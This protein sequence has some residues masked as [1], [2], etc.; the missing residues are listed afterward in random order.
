MASPAPV[1]SARSPLWTPPFLAMGLV[2]LGFFSAFHVLTPTFPLY[3]QARHCSGLAMGVMVSA[4]M[5]ASLLARPLMGRWADRTAKKPLL[6]L[7]AGVFALCSPL[8]LLPLNDMA[9]LG[10]RLAQGVAFSLF[11]AAYYGYLLPVLPQARRAEALS[12]HSNLVMIALALGP[13]AGLWV[14]R[15]V[16]L[17]TVF[18]VSLA[19]GLL[20]LLLCLAL[21]AEAAQQ[22][23]A[24]AESTS[25]GVSG[26]WI[27]PKALFPGAMMACVSALYGAVIP[28]VPLIGHEKGM[29]GFSALYLLYT[30][31]VILTRLISGTL[32]DRYGRPAVLIPA[33][34][35]S[36]LVT[37]AMAF[38]V[39][40]AALLGCA[41]AYGLASGA[42]QP[43]LMAMVADRLAADERA[44]AMA[45]FTLFGDIGMALG[46]LLVG[47]LGASMG[48]GLALTLPA[49]VALAGAA[50]L[51]LAHTRQRQQSPRVVQRLAP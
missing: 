37:W 32:S 43:S 30:L 21:P 34:A 39:G 38:S 19:L 49:T 17:A 22:D 7:G 28:F 4:F 24:P 40:P 8:Y 29:A 16:S 50:V 13:M 5:V 42:V 15:T 31:G 12:A 3:L 26:R 41:L 44:Q 6:L 9:L 35:L 11:V 45:T 14:M 10:L 51:W 47:A 23:T 1:Q 46:S 27:H 36:G 18:G 48:Y 33:M 2:A 20:T 25:A